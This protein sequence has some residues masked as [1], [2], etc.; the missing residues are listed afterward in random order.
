DRPFFFYTVPLRRLPEVLRDVKTLKA[1]QNGLLT[2]AALFVVS[3]AAALLFL[4]APLLARRAPVV[5][6]QDRGP[7]FRALLF[8]LCLGAGFVLVEIALVQHFVL[9][10]GHPVYALSAVLVILLLSAGVG[11]LLTARVAPHRAARSAAARAQLLVLA[12]AAVALGLGPLLGWGLGLTLPAR[13][14]LTAAVLVPLGLL[15]G[16]QAPLGV[17]LVNTRAPALLPWCWGLNGVASVVGIA[18]GTLIAMHLGYSAVLLLA[19]FTY[20]VGSA[21]VPPPG[22]EPE[23]PAAT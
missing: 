2:L 7:R 13:L 11:S 1:E 5:R 3:A 21:L 9:L 14:G 6:A 20:L 18:A 23:A 12:L 15:M 22:D 10:L 19:A 8:F 16:S 17:K 4:V